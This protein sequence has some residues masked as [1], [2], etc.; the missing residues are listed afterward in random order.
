MVLGQQ[1]NVTI[2]AQAESNI[3]LGYGEEPRSTRGPRADPEG[4]KG[5]GRNFATKFRDKAIGHR[6]PCR[7]PW[8]TAVDGAGRFFLRGVSSTR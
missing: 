1:T 7:T 6:Q 3:Q 5:M 4:W 8:L 2:E